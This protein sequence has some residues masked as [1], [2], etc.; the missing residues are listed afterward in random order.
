[1]KIDNQDFIDFVENC[2]DEQGIEE[3]ERAKA[4]VE[5]DFAF[6]TVTDD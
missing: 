4:I 5:K 2:S 1:V 6:V 3:F